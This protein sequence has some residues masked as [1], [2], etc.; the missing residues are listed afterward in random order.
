MLQLT[1][2][3]RLGDQPELLPLLAVPGRAMFLQDLAEGA[4]AL[5]APIAFGGIDIVDAQ[6]HTERR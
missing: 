5:P 3:V 6:I 2:A 1:V 4:L